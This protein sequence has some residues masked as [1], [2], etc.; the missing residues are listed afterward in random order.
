MIAV[1]HLGKIFGTGATAATV[2]RDVSLHVRPGEVFGIIGRS[3]AGKS[4]LV[5]CLN[6]LERP[7]A[8]RVVVAGQELTA[9]DGAALRAA[10]RRIG[11]IFQHFNV[12]SSRTVQDNVALPLE[13][14][15]R[16]R[17]QARREVL[18]LLELVGLTAHRDR[19]PAELSGGQKQRVGIARALASKPAVLL[20]DEAT[21]ALDPET[22]QSI[23]ALLADINRQLGLTIVLITHEMAVVQA[24]CDRVAV[25]DHGRVVEQGGVF[26][27]FTAPQA[28]V[29]RSLVRDVVDRE[30]PGWLRERLA[31]EAG[32]GR[33]PVLRIVFTGPSA[34]A[35]IIAEVV[36]RF[37]V[38]LN[39]LQAH[40]D[41]IQ[42]QPYGNIIVEADGTEAA[43]AGALEWIRGNGLKAEVL[44]HVARAGAAAPRRDA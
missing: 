7:T 19:F 32:P 35:P 2:L 40:V 44:G 25:L 39:I 22:T 42:G 6:L 31:A 4:T 29:T 11:M 8:G 37:D 41:Y 10:R 38:L 5:R 33:R 30:L 14:A 1:H 15:G 27:V 24:I 12:L 18:P 26:E 28:E 36:R 34:E 9:L 13:L 3:G 16:K 17:A 23:L 21:S 20:C 43:I